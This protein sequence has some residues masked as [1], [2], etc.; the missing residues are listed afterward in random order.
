MAI[1]AYTSLPPVIRRS[2]KK[3]YETIKNEIDDIEAGT[4]M[5]DGAITTAKLATNAVTTGKLANEAVTANKVAPHVIPEYGEGEGLTQALL[6]TAFGEVPATAK[7]MGIY[8]D[9]TNTKYYIVFSDGTV[10]QVAEFTLA[11]AP[12]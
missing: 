10:Y 5:A 1:P 2:R 6:T 4:D 9:S 7:F 3:L 11:T 12:E 8:K